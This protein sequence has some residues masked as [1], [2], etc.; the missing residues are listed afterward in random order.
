[1]LPEGLQYQSIEAIVSK[2]KSLGMNSIRLTYAIEMVDQIYE[3]EGNDILV[4]TSLINALGQQNGTAIYNK[5]I[6]NNPS[7]NS[8]TTRLQVNR[9]HA[10]SLTAILDADRPRFSTL[11]QQ[12]AQSRRSMF[13]WTIMCQQRI[14]AATRWTVTRGGETC[15]SP[16]RTGHGV[17]RTWQTT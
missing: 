4:Q 5:V 12:N 2:I 6:A 9:Q 17:C 13:I 3:N 11:W 14:G 7:F 16:H 10:T 1:M 15:T 8:S